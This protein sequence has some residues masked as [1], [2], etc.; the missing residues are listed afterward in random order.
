MFFV[1]GI[2]VGILLTIAVIITSKQQKVVI[3]K[4]KIQ[5]KYIPQESQIGE[6]I[7]ADEINRLHKFN[8]G[9]LTIDEYVKD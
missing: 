5:Q 7:D 9:E 8:N 4:E 6:I 2:I 1:L 3:I